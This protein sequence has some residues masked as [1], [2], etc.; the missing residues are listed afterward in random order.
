L[1]AA[2]VMVVGLGAALAV[3]A[4]WGQPAPAELPVQIAAEQPPSGLDPRSV[5]VPPDCRRQHDRT[6]LE[7]SGRCREVLTDLGITV[8][9]WTHARI[10]VTPE[11][12]VVHAGLVLVDV[13]EVPDGQPPVRV[14]V[15]GGTIEV[16]GTRFVIYEGSTG[17]EVRLLDGA[18]R[19]RRTGGDVLSLAPGDLARWVGPELALPVAEEEPGSPTAAGVSPTRAPARARPRAHARPLADPAVEPA[20]QAEVQAPSM[21]TTLDQ[22]A[23]LRSAGRHGAAIRAIRAFLDQAIVTRRQ[24]EV[25]S[26]EEG[27]LREVHGGEEA[28]CRHWMRHLE[29]FPGGS[30]AREVERHLGRLACP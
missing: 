9:T 30:Y 10:E 14:H 24:A 27:S 7:L 12:L 1:A 17:G 22:V 4:G 8:Q 28:S 2:L 25:L 3:S 19:L 6:A 11:G 23:R 26:F 18:I 20:A 29:R 13:E 21:E 5:V 15:G 16:L